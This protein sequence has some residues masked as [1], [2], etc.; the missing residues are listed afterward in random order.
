M[1]ILYVEDNPADADLAQRR[2]AQLAPDFDLDTVT[3]LQ[4]AMER[5]NAAPAYEM[6]LI[7]LRLPDG[8]GLDLLADI[9]ERKLPMA[10]VILTGSDHQEP[11]II[12]LK[13]GADDYLVKRGDYLQRLP[14]ALQDA[15]TRYLAEAA[16]K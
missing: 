6:A 11:A 15:R 1:K 4:E 16:F 8:S 5:L 14:Q 9:R 10:V 13:S 12:A 7:D 3:T 2:M